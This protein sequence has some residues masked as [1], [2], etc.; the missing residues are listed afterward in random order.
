MTAYASWVVLPA[1]VADAPE[2]LALTREVFAAYADVVPQPSSLRET[3]ADVEADLGSDGGLVLRHE[4]G[5]LVGAARFGS[6]DG[7]FWLRR[8]CVTESDRGRGLGSLLLDWLIVAARCGG[9]GHLMLEVR[10]DNV[11]AQR[12]Y[13]TRGFVMLTVRRKYYQPGDVDAHIMR[14]HLQDP[15]EHEAGELAP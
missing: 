11:A 9:A 14:L 2:V 10:A 12:L 3:L 5:A 8:L 7:G 13:S 6:G 15:T 4:S 1:T